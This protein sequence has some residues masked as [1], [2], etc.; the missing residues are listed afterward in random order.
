MKQFQV[1]QFITLEDKVFGPFTI[2]EFAYLLGGALLIIGAY[3]FLKPFLFWPVAALLAASSLSLAVFKIDGRPFRIFLKNA[4]F[5]ALRPKLYVWKKE[6]APP[7][8]RRLAEAK[9]PE[10][11]IK[12]IPRVEKSKLTDLAWSL[13]IKEE[14]RE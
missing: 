13:D 3:V 8:S 6:V 7:E 10:P 2:K 9:K 4:V 5:F 11:T 1:P 12:A 14:M